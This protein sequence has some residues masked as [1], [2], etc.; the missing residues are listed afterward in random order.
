MF[1]SPIPR[2]KRPN[3][4]SNP[5]YSLSH[6]ILQDLE[7]CRTRIGLHPLEGPSSTYLFPLLKGVSRFKLSPGRCGN[8]GGVATTLSPVAPHSGQLRLRGIRPSQ[9]PRVPPTLCPHHKYPNM[10]HSERA[11][12]ATEETVR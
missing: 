3:C 4:Y 6:Y 12:D 11:E 9:I 1:V 10:R 2:N 5:R 8:T 7:G